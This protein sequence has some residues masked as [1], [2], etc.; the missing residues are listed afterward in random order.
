MRGDVQEIFKKTPHE[1]QVMMFSATLSQDVRP[2]CKKF[3][4][5]V[6]RGL[7]GRGSDAPRAVDRGSLLTN[8]GFTSNASASPVAVSRAASSGAIALPRSMCRWWW[9]DGEG[10][11]AT[12]RAPATLVLAT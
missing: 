6:R 5:N 12:A 3:M 4:S 7:T 1:K 2:V 11:S 8:A 10:R 9:G